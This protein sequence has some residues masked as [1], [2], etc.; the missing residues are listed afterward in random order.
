MSEGGV[1]VRLWPML[2]VFIW[3][4]LVV[5]VVLLTMVLGDDGDGGALYVVVVMLIRDV[6]VFLCIPLR[7]RCT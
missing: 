4:C 6:S 2:V 3:Q 5:I 1:V 7:C